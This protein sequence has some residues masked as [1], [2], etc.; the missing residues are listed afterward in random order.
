MVKV[1]VIIPTY[2]AGMIL[3]ETIDSVLIQDFVDFELIIID[4]GSTDSTR[5]IVSPYLSSKVKYLYQSNAGVSAARNKGIEHSTGDY[6]FFLDSD[7]TIDRDL[8]GKM[9]DFAIRNSLDLVACSHDEIN[10]TRYGGNYNNTPSFIASSIEKISKYFMDIFPQS[11]CAK[12]FRKSLIVD[13]NILFPEEMHFG[14]DL[15]FTYSFLTVL[16]SYGKVSDIYYHIQN[17]NPNSLSKTYIP[18]LKYDI[19]RHDE[20][21]KKLIQ[22][23]PEIDETY[24]SKKLDFRYYLLSTYI[25]NFYKKGCFLTEKEKRE[26]IRNFMEVNP[27]WFLKINDRYKKPKNIMD[28][29]MYVILRTKNSFAITLF[30]RVKEFTKRVIR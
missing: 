24:H 4:D 18:N 17:V 8:I 12:L 19:K 15:F 7:D 27:E 3:K 21:W 25:S 9:Y 5:E 1:S 26:D 29:V 28:Y 30:F 22:I 16:T 11:A 13:N 2:N 14:E 6:L 20:L 10:S 23:Y